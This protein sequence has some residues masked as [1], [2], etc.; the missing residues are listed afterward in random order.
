MTIYQEQSAK[1]TQYTFC[2]RQRCTK[3][4]FSTVDMLAIPMALVALQ[5]A[6]ATLAR[7]AKKSVASEICILKP[8]TLK[9]RHEVADL[10]GHALR[11]RMPSCAKR[12][13]REC[14]HYNKTAKSLRIL[15]LVP[16]A[17]SLFE[18]H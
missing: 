15:I 17:I 2:K 5:K 18:K 6:A 13:G 10:E 1:Y 3:K 14:K 4:H 7:N 8:K 9:I 12:Q 11:A 16:S